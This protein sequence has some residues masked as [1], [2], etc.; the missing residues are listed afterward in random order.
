MT[1]ST[2]ENADYLPDP[3]MTPLAPYVGQDDLPAPDEE[4]I[5]ALSVGEPFHPDP[6]AR[7]R[8]AAVL[9]QITGWEVFGY[10]ELAA[11]E[12]PEEAAEHRQILRRRR[13][14]WAD[15]D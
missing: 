14:P 15:E 3:A 4:H 9:Y 11:S 10:A 8:I 7:A 13:P 2:V 12:T 5:H 1:I 6:Q